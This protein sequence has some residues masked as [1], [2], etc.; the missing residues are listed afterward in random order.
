MLT[1]GLRTFYILCNFIVSGTLFAEICLPELDPHPKI[2][3]SN[4]E[5][6]QFNQ[7][8]KGSDAFYAHHIIAVDEDGNGLMPHVTTVQNKD[9]LHYTA[10]WEKLAGEDTRGEKGAKEALKGRR[11]LYMYLDAMFGRIRCERPKRIVVHIHGGL[12]DIDGSIAKAA[13]LADYF[14][15]TNMHSD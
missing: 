6:R 9:G 12:N 8:T 2:P 3:Y 5:V 13:R 1:L 4:D 14:R 15:S 10:R 7:I 11:M